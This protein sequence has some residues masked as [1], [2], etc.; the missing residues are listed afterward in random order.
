MNLHIEKLRLV[1]TTETKRKHFRH[2]LKEVL[3]KLPE[4][5]FIPLVT[6]CL[7]SNHYPILEEYIRL[8]DILFQLEVNKVNI[9]K[10][11]GTSLKLVKDT[12][13]MFNSHRKTLTCILTSLESDGYS[14]E[15]IEWLCL[16]RLWS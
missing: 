11:N 12:K 2:I 1:G 16:N 13:Y 5:I 10:E 9:K 4:T 8:Y 6:E 15:I 7:H 3:R 14:P